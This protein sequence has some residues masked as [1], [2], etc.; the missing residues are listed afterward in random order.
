MVLFGDGHRFIYGEDITAF[1]VFH[2]QDNT[3]KIWYGDQKD[4]FVKFCV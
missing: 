1:E 2:L 3:Y 4:N